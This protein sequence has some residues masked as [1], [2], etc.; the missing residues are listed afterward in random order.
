M[1]IWWRN[2]IV[3]VCVVVVL[4]FIFHPWKPRKILML[5][6]VMAIPIWFLVSGLFVLQYN[7]MQ[8]LLNEG[9]VID[10]MSYLTYSLPPEIHGC[11]IINWLAFETCLLG[12][13]RGREVRDKEEGYQLSLNMRCYFCYIWFSSLVGSRRYYESPEIWLVGEPG[14]GFLSFDCGNRGRMKVANLISEVSR[15]VSLL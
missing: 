2:F 15:L 5:V 7:T 14:R 8:T 13:Q 3:E 10:P 6:R 12:D 1:S 9:D 11:Y 4:L